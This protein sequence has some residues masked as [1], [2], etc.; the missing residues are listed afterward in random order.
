MTR[1][2]VQVTAWRFVA[3]FGV[4]SLLAD[5]VY[6]GARSVSGPYLASLGASAVVVG[7]VTGAG[8]AVALAGRLATGP[9]TDRTRA[10]WPITLVGYGVTLAAVPLLGVFPALGV[11]A[12]L[13]LLERAGKA[14]RSPAK[15]VMLSHASAAVGRGKGFAVHEALDQIGALA[16]PLL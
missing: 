5:L 13:F 15:D 9:L 3:T 4:V 11:A 10:Y 16:G 1:T 14:I 6:E 8:E 7:V 12:A 2:S